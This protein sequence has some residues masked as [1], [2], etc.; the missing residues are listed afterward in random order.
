MGRWPW[1]VGRVPQRWAVAVVP[2]AC[3]LPSYSMMRMWCLP[4]NR[5]PMY[6][7]ILLRAGL[8][9]MRRSMM[10]LKTSGTIIAISMS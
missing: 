10:N 9:P 2:P 8:A 4:V 3:L 6:T 7:F 5:V 1:A